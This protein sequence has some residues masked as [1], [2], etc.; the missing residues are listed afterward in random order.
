MAQKA[1]ELRS[2][3]AVIARGEAL[4]SLPRAQLAMRKTLMSKG[5]GTKTLHL[6]ARRLM[7]IVP[8]GGRLEIE[9]ELA[10]RDADFVH[11]GQETEVKVEAFTSTR[12]GLLHGT[13]ESVSR[14]AVTGDGCAERAG[15]GEAP[16]GDEAHHA[17]QPGDV[18]RLSVREAGLKTEHGS[19]PIEAGMAVTAEIKTGRR[20]I[21]D[22]LLSPLLK[23]A[24]EGGRER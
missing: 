4:P 5:L 22:V 20:R 10:N 13:V 12:Y 17:R 15:S 21:I 3:K 19:Y 9:A 6:E 16:A 11:A 18:A 24:H 8:M 14:D 2:V 1:A 23:Y 7:V